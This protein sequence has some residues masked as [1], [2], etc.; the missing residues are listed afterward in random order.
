MTINLSS[1][2]ERRNDSLSLINN[3]RELRTSVRL[4]VK[5]FASGGW[6]EGT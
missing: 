1:H 5:S 2:R 4:L 3:S 6:F